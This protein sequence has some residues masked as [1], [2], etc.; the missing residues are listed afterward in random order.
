MRDATAEP[1]LPA[2]SFAAQVARSSLVVST[3]PLFGLGSGALFPLVALGVQDRVIGPWFIGLLAA[4]YYAG[5]FIGSLAW[6]LVIRRFGIANAFA[7]CM[8]AGAIGAA[9]F[10]LPLPVESWLVWRFATGIMAGAYYLTADT[11]LGGLTEPTSRG[12]IMG[13]SEALRIAAMGLGPW[14][15]VALP[16]AG[17]FAVAALLLVAAILPT[18]L[19][20]VPASLSA[21][22]RV[23]PSLAFYQQHWQALGL[24]V[25]SA[26]FNAGFNSLSAPAL[27]G[28]GVPRTSIPLAL[29]VAYAAG[30]VGLVGLGMLG[31]F[32]LRRFGSRRMVLA[33]AALWA[34]LA[35]VTLALMPA[36]SPAA[37]IGLCGVLCIAAF[38]FF[39]ISLQRLFDTVPPAD[40][41]RAASAAL[42]VYNT[43]AVVSGQTVGL[44]L[45]AFG[46]RGVFLAFAVP[47]AAA[48]IMMLAG[49]RRR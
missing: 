19:A 31:D 8:L 17:G 28:L 48:L 13:T 20:P 11:W 21:P 38:P 12:R 15:I 9:G 44:V 22:G 26:T 36:V 42:V 30:G 24:I 37:V 23:Y 16:E 14:V 47:F 7:L 46:P 6:P 45:Q 32:A 33:T 49:R 35:S 43:T 25:V 4:T 5:C 1:A 3:S 34:A 39:G 2:P 18:R 27:A 10:A 40:T 29:G 41:V